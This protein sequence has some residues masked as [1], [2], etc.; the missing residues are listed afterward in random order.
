MASGKIRN[1]RLPAPPV[2][3]ELMDEQHGRTTSVGLVVQL[4][5]VVGQG[6]WHRWPPSDDRVARGDAAIHRNDGATGIAG[7]VGCQEH[8]QID[9]LADGRGPVQGVAVL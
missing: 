4:D 1:L 5:A 2:S 3:A 8:H 9:D 7:A 6:G